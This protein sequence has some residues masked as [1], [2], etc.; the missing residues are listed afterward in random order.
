MDFTEKRIDGEYKYNGIIVNV[1]MDNAEL[2]NGHIVKREVVEHPGGVAVV[3]V[4]AE[5]NV[6]MV[7]QYRYPIEKMMLE[8]PAGK[9]EP[10]EEILISA[11]RELSE[12]TGFSADKMIYMGKFATS[13]GITTEMLHLY[14]ALELH[15]GVTHPDEDEYLNILKYPLEELSRMVMDGEITDGKTVIAILKAEKYLKS[16]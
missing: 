3:P 15:E 16:L 8:V 2:F 4:D 5:G 7:E 1:R 12:E 6:Y 11:E 9:L 10:G 14:L 13:P